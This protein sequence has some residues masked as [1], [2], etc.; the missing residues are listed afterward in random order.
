MK[1][2]VEKVIDGKQDFEVVEADNAAQAIN[3]CDG[4]TF[5]ENGNLIPDDRS[6]GYVGVYELGQTNLL[7]LVDARNEVHAFYRKKLNEIGIDSTT[8]EKI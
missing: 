8:F 5:D 2:A 3:L 7:D 1:L 6:I 4:I